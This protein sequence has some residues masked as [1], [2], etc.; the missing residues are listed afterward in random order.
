MSSSFIISHSNEDDNFTDI[1]AWNYE[2]PPFLFPLFYGKPKYTGAG[3]YCEAQKG[4]QFIEEMYEF[5]DRHKEEFFDRPYDFFDYK[6]K[7]LKIV[8]PRGEHYYLNGTHIFRLS[9]IED[10]EG[11]FLKETKNLYAQIEELNFHIQSA[12]AADDINAFSE[13]ICPDGV[14]C[15]FESLGEWFND[16]QYLYG[17]A[18]LFYYQTPH[19]SASSL[20]T[21]FHENEKQGLK[22]ANGDKITEA[23]Y[24]V[25]YDFDDSSDF[26]VVKLDGK[27]GYIDGKGN[28]FIPLV[29]DDAYD[30]WGAD[31]SFTDEGLVASAIYRGIVVK[32]GKY[33]VIDEKNKVIIPCAWDDIFYKEP[34][35]YFIPNYFYVEKNGKTG[36]F[37][38]KGVEKYPPVIDRY[39]VGEKKS[40]DLENDY[41][42]EGFSECLWVQVEDKWFYL[43]NKFQPYGQGLFV[44]DDVRFHTTWS[45]ED[46]L[47]SDNNICLLT[48]ANQDGF[49]GLISSNDDQLIPIQYTSVD[50][51]LGPHGIYDYYI[52]EVRNGDLTELF[53]VQ[54]DLSVDVIFSDQCEKITHFGWGFNIIEVLIG[55]KGLYD[56]VKKRYVLSPE[57]DFF[58]LFNLTSED[59]AVFAVKGDDLHQYDPVT[60]EWM[61]LNLNDLDYAVENLNIN[62]PDAM[63][64]WL[65]DFK[66]RL[67]A[68]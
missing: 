46:E 21:V 31:R 59:A 7:I 68:H 12:I 5:L 1:L 51:L 55:K 9:F 64:S 2:L 57:Y 42:V 10:E 35:N 58:I 50:V 54:K 28:E 19:V 40:E 60:F 65:D 56:L 17:F 24:D 49:W 45:Q 39:F 29:Y 8:K 41:P 52:F 3:F 67:S 66:R 47:D 27:F 34:D 15:Y 18:T 11:L 16:A 36:I 20:L 38:L 25:I 6:N 26:A 4:Y 48:V 14:A 32:D 30:F 23:K 63:I 13:I 62:L 33:G 22:L 61:D 43:N 44:R 53:K 37:D